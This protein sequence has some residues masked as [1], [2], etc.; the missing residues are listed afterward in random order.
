[1]ANNSNGIELIGVIVVVVVMFIIQVISNRTQ[2]VL[3][4]WRGGFGR[5]ICTNEQ[6]FFLPSYR[7]DY[8]FTRIL[9]ENE[10]DTRNGIYFQVC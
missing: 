5:I 1:M 3:Y 9:L 2:C 4:I 8:V 7:V 6:F 10:N